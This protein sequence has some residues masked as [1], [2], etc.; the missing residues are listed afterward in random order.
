MPMLTDA[1]AAYVLEPMEDD[2]WTKFDRLKQE[3]LERYWEV[4][5]FAE[6]NINAVWHHVISQ[7]GRPCAVCGKPLRTPRA[8][9]CAACGASASH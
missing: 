9:L 7:Y 4:T 1:E 8:K 5:G 6:S 2:D 3:S